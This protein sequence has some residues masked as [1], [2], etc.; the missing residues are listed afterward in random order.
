MPLAV[1]RRQVRELPATVTLD[2]SMAMTPAAKLSDHQ[3]VVVGAR[4]SKTG[5]ASP[6]PGDLQGIAGPVKAGSRDASVLIDTE[7]R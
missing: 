1:A 4:I 5:S 3:R 2:D 7:V 6:Q